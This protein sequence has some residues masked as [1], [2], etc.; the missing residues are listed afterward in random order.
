M[1]PVEGGE[2]AQPN[3]VRQANRV[4][5]YQLNHEGAWEDQGTGYAALINR[6][7]VVYAEEE[8]KPSTSV[9]ILEAP[10]VA[11]D[12]YQRQGDT[13]ISWNDPNM[14]VDLALSFQE[15]KQCSQFWME[16]QALQGRHLAQPGCPQEDRQ[17]GP[18]TDDYLAMEQQQQLP[19]P[20]MENLGEIA[21][22]VDNCGLYQREYMA[23]A[24]ARKEYLRQ[25][26]EQFS[27]CEDLDNSTGLNALFRI[28]KGMVMLND[29]CLLEMLLSEEYILSVI[30]VLEYDPE[31]SARTAHRDYLTKVV[32]FKEV[33]KIE[34]KTVMSNIHQ[35]FRVL[36]LKDVI[37][38]KYLDD[39]TFSALSTLV[40]FNS[41]EIIN[42]LQA[43]AAFLDT[44]FNGLLDPSN[45]IQRL[46][47]LIG[48]L[49]ELCAMAKN[50]QVIARG[51]FYR[52]LVDRNLFKVLELTVNH[53]VRSLRL[54]AVDIAN[55]FISQESHLCR[56]HMMQQTPKCAL[57]GLLVEQLFADNDAGMKCQL[58]ELIRMLLDPEMM[59]GT[60][61]KD[62][63]LNLFYEAFM[64]TLVACVSMEQLVL[65]KMREFR[66]K[67]PSGQCLRE[68][69]D[70]DTT[71]VLATRNQVC[72]ILAFCVQHHGYRIKYFILRHNIVQKAL[73]LVFTQKKGHSNRHVV[74]NQLT[75][76]VMRFVRACVGLKDEF[77]NRHLVKNNLFDPIMQAFH[78]NGNRY[79]LFNS[80]VIELV[81][82][83]RRENVKSLVAHLVGSHSDKFNNADY[84]STFKDL[85]RKHEQNIDS[86]RPGEERESL[87]QQQQ[88]QQPWRRLPESDD[89]AYFNESDSEEN[90]EPPPALSA[91]DMAVDIGPSPPPPNNGIPNKAGGFE[92]TNFDESGAAP[93][94]NAPVVASDLVA[95]NSAAVTPAP[96]SMPAVLTADDLQVC[97]TQ[98]P[99]TQDADGHITKR[100]K[101]DAS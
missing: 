49:Q 51:Q 53:S 48:L 74:N 69:M 18:N 34:D 75:L 70:A 56:A 11:D 45:D 67:D 43:D 58:A 80:S 64:E 44:L 97:S 39:H 91:S 4:K 23:Q 87:Q 13:I 57:M 35:N 55:G 82:F 32:I 85:V 81:D 15:A 84:V 83:C 21:N 54:S 7:I 41:V 19:E 33:V 16:V 20:S 5:V 90:V 77:Y 27:M 47:D 60:S 31:L 29:N 88:T 99:N 68:Q 8:E 61:E 22:I 62:D 94:D 42:R 14:A 36:Y 93:L 3:A 9:V 10:V 52:K 1:E 101:V 73:H 71:L 72:E 50:L 95:P 46:K 2:V 6:Y 78:A 66:R 65:D 63:F 92:T 38:A 100:L 12:V 89:D 98:G 40:Y 28:F 26:F 59:E 79:N 37:L 86:D 30:G 24:F 76:T 96:N 17:L 25:L